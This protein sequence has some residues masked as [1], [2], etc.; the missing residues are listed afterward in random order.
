MRE[1]QRCCRSGMMLHRSNTIFLICLF[2]PKGQ[3]KPFK[4]LHVSLAVVKLGSPALHISGAKPVHCPR[5][6]GAALS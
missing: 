5:D 4:T 3:K 6:G 2:A 1:K